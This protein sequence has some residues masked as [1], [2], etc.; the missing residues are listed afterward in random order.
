[1]GRFEYF[2]V[3]LSSI[4]RHYVECALKYHD[5]EVIAIDPLKDAVV[6]RRYIDDSEFTTKGEEDES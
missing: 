6:L 1:M 5:W 2:K 4:I 3:F